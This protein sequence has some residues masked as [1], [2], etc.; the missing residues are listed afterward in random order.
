MRSPAAQQDLDSGRAEL[1]GLVQ[2]TSAREYVSQAMSIAHTGERGDI[3]ALRVGVD[4]Q[5]APSVAC[6]GGGQV[7]GNRRR[8]DSALPTGNG[9]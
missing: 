4:Q 9:H 1:H 5:C 7:Q 8:T 6:H 2:R 3:R